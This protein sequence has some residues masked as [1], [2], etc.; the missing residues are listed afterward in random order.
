MGQYTIPTDVLQGE[1]ECLQEALK[2]RISITM[3][4]EG[5]FFSMSFPMG[6]YWRSES[7]ARRM[8]EHIWSHL[9]E[10]ILLHYIALANEELQRRKDSS[11]APE[12]LG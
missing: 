10:P 11:S 12:R 2:K 9:L 1:L 8:G 4:Q 6:S 3:R 5:E 7:S